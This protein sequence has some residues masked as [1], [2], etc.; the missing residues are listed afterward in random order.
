MIRVLVAEDN[1]TNRELLRELLDLKGYAISEAGDGKEALEMIEQDPPDLLLLDLNMPVLD[2]FGVI[3]KVRGNPAWS[4]LPVVAVTANAMQG[5]KERILAA[6]FDGYVSK[7]LSFQALSQE[8]DR[9]LS[10]REATS[11]GASG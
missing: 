2:G 9:L 1:P 7:P 11:A 10:T 5:D 3:A 8:L 4:H 6:G